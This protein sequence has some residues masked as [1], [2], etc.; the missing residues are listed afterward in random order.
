MCALSK[1][2]TFTISGRAWKMLQCLCPCAPEQ[3]KRALIL[4]TDKGILILWYYSSNN[5]MQVPLVRVLL[6]FMH[7]LAMMSSID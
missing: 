2:K 6:L 1:D 3:A 4:V 5:I 7:G